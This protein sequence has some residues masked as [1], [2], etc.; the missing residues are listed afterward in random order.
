MTYNKYTNLDSLLRVLSVG[1]FG[2]FYYKGMINKRSSNC[3]K[4]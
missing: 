3:M 4:F 2:G 1:E